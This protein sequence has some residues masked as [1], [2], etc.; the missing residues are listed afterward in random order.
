MN[1]RKL[2]CAGLTALA[3]ILSGLLVPAPNARA[4]DGLTALFGDPVLVRGKNVDVKQSQLD[5]EFITLRASMAARQEELPEAQRFKAELSLLEQ[6]IV[7]Q[8][9]AV[10][11]T[12]GDKTNAAA[13]S[14][15]F[16]ENAR[17]EAGGTDEGLAR[18]V[19][20]MGMSVKQ[21]E[22]RLAKKSLSET[23]IERELGPQI[24]L[25]EE[26]IKKFY[27]DNVD[28]F[29][30]P[31]IAKGQYIIVY[32]RDPKTGVDLTAEQIKPKRERLQRAQARAKA[33]ED[34]MS[35][36]KE[37]SEE[38]ETVEKKGEFTIPKVNRL[39]EVESAVFGQ[40]INAVS[41]IIS[42]G[43]ALHILKVTERIPAR[44]VEFD[45]VKEDIKKDLTYREMVKKLPEYFGKLKKEANLEV[46][47]AKY[48][49]VL[50]TVAALG[51]APEE[52]P[53]P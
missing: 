44:Q 13:V 43:N 47:D 2:L 14:K 17:R 32:T 33:G 38:P 9:L 6:L 50:E 24:A 36:V 4:A 41:D 3:W 7:G 10:H 26:M 52:K 8:I 39:P 21:Y 25:T 37:Y 34:F 18:V 49:S 16:L 29:Q 30:Q 45:K 46:I 12:E 11:A 53:K 1:S 31:D 51:S 22:D 42:A 5:E 23:V 15:R 40:P 35:L 48:K 20:S 19:R 27:T 28:K